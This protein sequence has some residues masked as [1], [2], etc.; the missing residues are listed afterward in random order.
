MRMEA[1]EKLARQMTESLRR[2]SLATTAVA[3][4]ICGLCVP[5]LGI[6]GLVLGIAAWIRVKRCP[7]VYRG[8]GDAIAAVCIG[9]L[10]FVTIPALL[11][12]LRRA[13]D[14]AHRAVC[15][16][17]LRGAGQ[18]L[19]MYADANQGVFPPDLTT[20]VELG[21]TS[22]RQ[23]QCPFEGNVDEASYDYQYFGGLTDKSPPAWIIMYE[24]LANHDNEGGNV[25][26]VDRQVEFIKEPAYTAEVERVRRGISESRSDREP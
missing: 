26:Y 1:E 6:L 25:L 10:N 11:M 23:F 13:H 4:G 24:H 20:L 8:T 18:A 5:G 21:M 22:A 3:L 14:L 19:R 16:A 15:S 2:N 7:G 12:S 17:N 9:A